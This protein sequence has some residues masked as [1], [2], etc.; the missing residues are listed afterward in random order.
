MSFNRH[1]T[2]CVNYIYKNTKLRITLYYSILSLEQGL[3]LRATKRE[4]KLEDFLV[5]FTHQ[6][7]FPRLQ[8]DNF[9][10]LI[11]PLIWHYKACCNHKAL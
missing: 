2:M 8:D 6:T 11:S 1:I 3:T 9:I 7:H 4:Y 5:E 10:T